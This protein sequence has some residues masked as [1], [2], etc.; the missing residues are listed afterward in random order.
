VSSLMKE[1]EVEPIDVASVGDPAIA[2]IES[3]QPQ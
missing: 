2:D 3:I 1:A